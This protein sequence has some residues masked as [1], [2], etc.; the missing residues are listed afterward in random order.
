MIGVVDEGW[1]YDF[2]NL[3]KEFTHYCPNV[4]DSTYAYNVDSKFVL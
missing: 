2:S 4:V 1:Y 3:N